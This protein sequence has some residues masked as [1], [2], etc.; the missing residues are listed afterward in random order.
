MATI[1]TILPEGFEEIEAITPIDLWRRAEFDVTVASLGAKTKVTGRSGITL[2]AETSL[3]AIAQTQTFDLLFL[4]GG[5]GR[6]SF[7]GIARSARPVGKA[8]F[9]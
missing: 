9:G 7:T 3:S 2:H 8:G 4:P 6:L 5:A 1:L